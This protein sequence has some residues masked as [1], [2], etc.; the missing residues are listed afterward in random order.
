LATDGEGEFCIAVGPVTR[1]AG[2]LLVAYW[3]LAYWSVTLIDVA[4]D[5]TVYA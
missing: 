1:T 3:V 2:I 5:F 4:T